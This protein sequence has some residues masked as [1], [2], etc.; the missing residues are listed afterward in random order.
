MFCQAALI[1]KTDRQVKPMDKAM[2]HIR[3]TE[4]L[5]EAVRKGEPN[6][7]WFAQ[8]DES[9]IEVMPYD[10]AEVGGWMLHPTL[11]MVLG[12]N[13][14]LMDVHEK[15]LTIHKIVRKKY[16]EEYH[17]DTEEAVAM[18]VMDVLHAYGLEPSVCIMEFENC[19]QRFTMDEDKA[20]DAI[21][22]AQA[23]RH[24]AVND[25]D[26]EPA[27]PCHVCRWKEC[28]ERISRDIQTSQ[29]DGIGEIAT[30]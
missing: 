9:E 12:F 6:K 30:L 14:L 19:T 17:K 7:S 18:L 23:A 3:N 21:E 13:H 11:L 28:P 4:Q 26:V 10:G 16:R 29:L 1:Q 27:Y 22:K 15:T 24:I 25:G 20:A 2:W 8:A 5:V